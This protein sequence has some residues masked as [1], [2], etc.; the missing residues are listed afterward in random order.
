[1]SG[2]PVNI[3]KL[4]RTYPAN[5]T[6]RMPLA[7]E[8]GDII[9]HN[10]PIAGAAFWREHIKVIIPTIGLALLLVETFFPE[11]LSAL[12]AEEVLHMPSLFQSGHAFL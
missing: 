7:V 11:L 2:V 4:R 3:Y 10:R 5:E 6:V 1:M 8:R 9:F 12:S